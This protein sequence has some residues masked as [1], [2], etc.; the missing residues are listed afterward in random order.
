[1]AHPSPPRQ[2]QPPRPYGLLHRGAEI[3]ATYPRKWQRVEA[4]RTVLEATAQP[5]W[6]G[7]RVSTAKGIL[8]AEAVLKAALPPVGR[9]T[10]TSRA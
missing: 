10:R 4:F 5:V 8:D 9:C 3:D 2:W 6:I 1:M 7:L